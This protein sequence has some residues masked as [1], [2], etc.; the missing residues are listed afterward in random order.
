[1]VTKEG[2]FEAAKQS[3]IERNP[4]MAKRIAEQGL[5]EGIDPVSLL[6]SGFIPGISEIGE[7]FGM[8]R[9]FLPELIQAADTMEQVM[10]TVNTAFKTPDEQSGR[11]RVLIGTV[12]GDYH[13]IG[14]AI[15]VALFKAKG[16]NV[17]DL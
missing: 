3:I 8:G 9:I 6:N 5:A 17:L 2:I 12:N 15:V 4:M 14:K 1:M 16:F 10:A 7:L 11:G 13:D